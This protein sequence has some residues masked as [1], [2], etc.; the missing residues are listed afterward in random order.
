MPLR[1]VTGRSRRRC[2]RWPSCSPA[3][4]A[5]RHI[6]DG[7]DT[8]D[9]R[10][11]SRRADDRVIRLSSRYATAKADLCFSQLKRQNMSPLNHILPVMPKGSAIGVG[12]RV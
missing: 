12:R 7:M 2:P 10:R 8:A 5:R 1:G 3:D 11:C 9:I 4:G 6:S